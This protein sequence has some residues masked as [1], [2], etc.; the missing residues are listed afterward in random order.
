MDIIDDILAGDE[1]DKKNHTEV[2]SSFGIIV[3][4]CICRMTLKHH[5]CMAQILMTLWTR[6][7]MLK[8]KIHL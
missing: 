3:L 1:G 7:T 6:V 8:M 2:V 4:I 5:S